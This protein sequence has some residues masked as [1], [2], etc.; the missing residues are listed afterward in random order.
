MPKKKK[1]P[2]EILCYCKGICYPN[3]GG[4]MSFG[5]ALYLAGDPEPFHQASGAIE[6][7]QEGTTW[8][9]Y[10]HAILFALQ[11][12]EKQGRADQV[13]EVFTDLKGAINQINHYTP[14]FSNVDLLQ[15]ITELRR[16]FKKVRWFS[17]TAEENALAGELARKAMT[18][19]EDID[20]PYLDSFKRMLKE[21]E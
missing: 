2:T 6:D 18:E 4:L 16:R 12:L 14:V 17:I 7:N 11:D 3:P 20:H 8:R 13:L 5:Y 21:L 1:L 15:Q 9:A 10:Y 19:A